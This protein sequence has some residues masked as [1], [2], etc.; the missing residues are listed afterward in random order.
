MLRTAWTSRPGSRPGRRSPASSGRWLSTLHERRAPSGGPAFASRQRSVPLAHGRD[1]RELPRPRGWGRA[2]RARSF[3]LQPRRSAGPRRP[4]RASTILRCGQRLFKHRGWPRSRS[5]RQVPPHDR[6]PAPYDSWSVRQ[7]LPCWRAG[8]SG[9][10]QIQADGVRLERVIEK[11]NGANFRLEQTR[12]R[13]HE[14]E[15]RLS[16]ARVSLKKAHRA[17][18]IS[19]QYLRALAART[20]ADGA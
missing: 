2:A 4:T 7:R 8:R 14:N 9:L 10:S 5:R 1:P 6:C 17:L 20:A 12:Q 19:H 16:T 11:Y 15:V 18:N 3:P 13:I